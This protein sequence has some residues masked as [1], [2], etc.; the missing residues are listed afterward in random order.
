MALTAKQLLAASDR[1]TKTLPIPAW[2]GDVVIGTISKALARAIVRECVDDKGEPDYE[3]RERRY[4][5][6]CLVEPQITQAQADVLY[7]QNG[8]AID[9]ILA[10]WLKLSAMTA[11]GYMTKQ[12][13]DDAERQFPS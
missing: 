1:A 2:G 5:Q 4:L 13:V 8:P 3:M 9:Y 6:A 7:Q 11:D 10:E 12:G